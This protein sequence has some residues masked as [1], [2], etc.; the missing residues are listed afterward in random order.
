MVPPCA[1]MG[2]GAWHAT[3]TCKILIRLSL[4]PRLWHQSSPEAGGCV[5]GGE[6]QKYHAIITATTSLGIINV[7]LAHAA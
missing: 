2:R 1:D 3:R 6:A 4:S 7:L 5:G